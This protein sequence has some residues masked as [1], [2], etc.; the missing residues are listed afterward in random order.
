MKESCASD[1]DLQPDIF[2]DF[3][4]GRIWAINGNGSFQSI[5]SA[6]DLTAILDGGATGALSSLASFGQGAGGELFIVDFAGKVVQVVPE[7][8]SVLLMLGGVL[9]QLAVRR[10]A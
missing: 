4:S 1:A 6:T 10:R 2:G 8:A 5:A 3:V 9:G 7:P